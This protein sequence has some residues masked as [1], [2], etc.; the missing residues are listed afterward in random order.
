MIE[1]DKVFNIDIDGE[2]D[3]E[4][5]MSSLTPSAGGGPTTAMA[6]TTSQKAVK[7]EVDAKHFSKQT[8][9][10][11]KNTRKGGVSSFR[12]KRSKC[13]VCGTKT[14]YFCDACGEDYW[15]CCLDTGRKCLET[16]R[17]D[18]VKERLPGIVL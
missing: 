10:Q 6:S 11:E 8:D 4:T 1:E 13:R 16:H 7:L 14:P 5:I 9:R 12:T 18:V 15:I 2:D 17:V 3:D